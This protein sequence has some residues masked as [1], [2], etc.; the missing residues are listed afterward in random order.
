MQAFVGVVRC[1]WVGDHA[2]LRRRTP[3][4]SNLDTCI[5]MMAD[6]RFA[7]KPFVLSPLMFGDPQSRDRLYM[8]SIRERLLQALQV[9]GDVFFDIIRD[10]AHLHCVPHHTS[11]FSVALRSGLLHQDTDMVMDRSE[12]Y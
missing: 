11:E 8:P 12:P 3:R 2:I 5:T 9:D 4:F 10:L 6:I 1:V 7:V